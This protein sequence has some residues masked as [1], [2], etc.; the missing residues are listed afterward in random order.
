MPFCKVDEY[1]ILLPG[2]PAMFDSAATRPDIEEG[3]AFF[4][5][6]FFFIL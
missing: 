3:D 6:R 2:R 1:R 5:E 4:L